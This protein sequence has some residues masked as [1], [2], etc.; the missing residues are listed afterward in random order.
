MIMPRNRLAY[1]VVIAIVIGAGLASRSG[2]AD[3]LPG[4][5]AAYAGDTLWALMVFLFLG[6]VFSGWRIGVVAVAAIAI[7][8]SVEFSQLYQSDWLNRIRET[9]AGALLLGSGFLWSDLLCYMTGVLMGVAGEVVSLRWRRGKSLGDSRGE[10]GA[11]F[12]WDVPSEGV[13]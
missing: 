6:I 11:G 5:V 2:L 1:A 3:Y 8:F 9:R 12:E 4:F 7:S 13:G 10:K